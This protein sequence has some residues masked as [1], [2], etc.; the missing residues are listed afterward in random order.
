[1]T[2]YISGVLH[3]PLRI[4]ARVVKQVAQFEQIFRVAYVFGYFVSHSFSP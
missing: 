4:F 2:D 3:I 1:M